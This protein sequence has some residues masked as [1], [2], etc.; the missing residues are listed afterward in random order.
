M[1]RVKSPPTAIDLAL[2]ALYA[3]FV[4]YT[5]SHVEGCPH[6]V[7]FEDSAALRRAPLRQ[8]GGELHRYL[9]K[10][11]TTWGTNDDFKHFV[12]RLVELYA[13]SSD[14]WLLC[15]KLAY[16]SWRAWPE[17]EQRAVER[18]LQA[19]WKDELA[20]FGSPLPGHA[21][22]ETMAKLDIDMAPYDLRDK[23]ESWRNEN[24]RESAK[25]MA[26]FVLEHGAAL[27]WSTSSRGRRTLWQEKPEIALEV[28]DWLLAPAI[29][30][31]LEASFVMYNDPEVARAF[32]WLESAAR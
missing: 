21:L 19:L 2:E 9:F 7:S 15:D 30:D 12:P 26:C 14:A 8:L 6:C 32:D 28:H 23:L 25:A 13:W 31:W 22:L 29:R 16:A 18:Y 17:H 24:S 4:Q 27:F 10:A 3:A 5:G 20:A 11:M 1:P